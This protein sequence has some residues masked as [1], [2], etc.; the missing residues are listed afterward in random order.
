MSIVT[1]IDVLWLDDPA[2][3]EVAQAGGKA[4]QLSKLA[5]RQRV[6]PGFCLAAGT[7]PLSLPGL[8]DAL[9]PRVAAAYDEL[10][11]RVGES[12]PAVAVR[13]SGVD[14]DGEG[15]SFAGQFDSYLNLTGAESVCDA[16]VRCWRSAENER[17]R[18]YRRHRGLRE[19]AGIAV[20]VQ[21]LVAADISVVAFS[22][23]P[24]TGDRGHIVINANL[25]LGESIVGGTVTPDSYTVCKADL[26]ISEIRVSEKARMTITVPG[27]TKEVAVPRLLQSIQVMNEEQIAEVARL[28]LECEAAM[29]CPVDIECAFARGVLYLLQCRPITTLG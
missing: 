4:A 1:E 9:W 8:M 10:G 2:T 13:S 11:R 7:S 5:V 26:A 22:A 15:S 17:A 27:G 23:N 6:P 14:E 25:G 29:G 12:A 28:T 3:T 21:H 19:G 18:A 20:L 16:V 24:V